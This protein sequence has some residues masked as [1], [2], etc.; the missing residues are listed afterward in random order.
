M[1]IILTTFWAFV[2]F[3]F[4]C[5]VNFHMLI[6]YHIV[7]FQFN[8]IPDWSEL[9]RL[10]FQWRTNDWIHRKIGHFLGFFILAL[11]ASNFG[12]YKSAFFFSILYAALTEIL[13]LFFSRGG[14]IY[15]I[16]NDSAGILFAY[17]LC[18]ILFR[19]RSKRTR[20]VMLDSKK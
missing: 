8:P 5:S 14:R 18:L 15:D 12:K 10:D 3:V 13:Q 17:L 20:N 1:R 19:K 2:L 4:T 9:L 7:D 6:R 11:L 16:A